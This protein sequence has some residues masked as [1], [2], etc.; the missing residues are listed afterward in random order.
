MAAIIKGLIRLKSNLEKSYDNYKKSP[1]DRLA[2][3]SYLQTRLESL[4]S[5]WKSISESHS[6]LTRGITDAILDHEYFTKDVFAD[7]E[8]IYINYKSDI[9]E[10][11]Y[12]CVPKSS[13]SSNVQ[14]I[15]KNESNVS[16]PKIN[17]PVFTGQ[18]SEWPSFRDLYTSLIHNN[19]SLDN[20]QKMHYLK[21]HLSGEAGQLLRHVPITGDS[22]QESWSI[23]NG[24]YNN[25]KYLA[26][27]LLRRFM[28]Q[29]SIGTESCSAIK[30][31]LDTTND[32]LNGLKNLGIR[33]DSWDVIIIYIICMKI[34]SE[35]RKQWE[36]KISVFD[37]LPTLPQMREFLEARFRSLEFLSPKAKPKTS[38]STQKPKVLH[39]ISAGSNATTDPCLFCKNSNHKL[40]Q[41]KDFC[42]LD[43][44][45][46]HSFVQT[47]GFCFNCLG[48]NHSANACRTSTK[49]RI[50]KHNH[51]SLLH[52]KPTSES[53]SSDSFN[54]EVTLEE[55]YILPKLQTATENAVSASNVA[56]HFSKAVAPSRILL[57][58]AIVKAQKR[59]GDIHQ[60][61][62]L[63]DQGSQASFVT[64]TVVQL[65]NLKKIPSKSIISGLGGDKGTLASRHMV[66]ITVNSQ[67]DPT[68]KMEVQAHVL[69]SITG[70][71]PS[72]KVETVEW[73]EL[74]GF[75][76]ADPDFKTPNKIDILLGADAYGEVLREGLIKGPNGRLIAQHTALGWVLSGP[77][78][79][80]HADQSSSTQS[81][82]NMI[83]STQA[84]VDENELLKKFW[85]I[86]SDIFEEKILTHEEQ[87]CEEFY[88]QTTRRD[89]S[90]RYIVELPFNEDNPQCKYGN[91]REIALKRFHHLEH[92]FKKDPE[93][94]KR[95]TEV[96]HEYLDLGHMERVT[97]TDKNGPCVYLPHHAVIRDSKTTSKIR[98]VFDASC[99]GTNGVSLNDTLMVGPTLQQDLRHIIMRWR[100]HPIC[101]SADI[102]KMYRQVLVAQKDADFQR[103]FW[104]DD[105][106][107]EIEEYRLVRVTFG[108]ASAPYLAV[109]TLQQ[110]AIDEAE[111]SASGTSEKIKTDYYVDDLL[112]GC[113][114]VVEGIR[115]YEEMTRILRKGGF[116]L[117]KWVTNNKELAK[118]VMDRE[119]NQDRK[120]DIKMDEVVKIL[121]LSW[122]KESDS[123]HYT[124][125]L[126]ILQNPVTK[127]KVISD[128]SRLFDP[129][130]WVA[131]CVIVAK[132]MIQKLW[133]SGIDWDE[134]LPDNLLEE[135]LTYR[136][137]ITDIIDFSIPRWIQAKEDDTYREI[138]GFCD[139]SNAAYAGVVYLRTI[140][141]NGAVHV[142]LVTAKTKV[143]PTMQV[144][145]PRL[146]L[147]G[148]VLVAKLST[149]VAKVLNIDKANIHGWTDST[150]VL[151]WLSSHPCRW[152]TFIANRT[153]EILSRLDSSQWSHV[154]SLQN[155]ADVASRGCT[156]SELVQND[157]WLQ[158]P[159]WLQNPTLEYKRPKIIST[160][161]EE[162]HIKAH[163]AV[164]NDPIWTRFSS[165]Q[166]LTH[167]VAFCLR[168]LKIKDVRAKRHK[169]QPFLE[170][171][172]LINALDICIMQC[173]A[174]ELQQDDSKLKSLSPYKDDKGI[175]RAQ[176]RIQNCNLSEDTKHPIIL[177]HKSHLTNL[178]IDDAHKQTLHGGP[179]LMLNYL[180]TRYW[181]ISAKGLVRRHVHKCVTC[182]RHAAATKN[183]LM[184]QLPPARVT[185]S[186]PFL[187]SG[188]DFAG[189]INI[190]VSKG[191]G[192]KSYKGYISLFICMATKA[193][194][195]EVISDLT[196]Q[197]F[198]AGFKRFVA[199]RGHV[200]HIWSDN[201]TNFVG[202]AKELRHL[203]AAEDSSVATEIRAWLGTK[204]VTWHFIPP[205]APNF[206][207]LWEAGVKSA[208]FHLKRVVNNSTLTFEEMTTVLSQ[209]EACLNSRPLSMLPNDH[210]DPSPLTPGHFLVG[211]PLIVVPERN[212]EQSNIGTLKRWQMTQRMLQDFWRR[213]SDEYLVHCL[214]RHKWT[215]LNP[216]PKIGDVVLIKE[217]NLPPARWLL[218]R[219][220]TKHPGLDK[221]TRVVT[222]KCNGVLLKRPTS[223]LCML[224]VTD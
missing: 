4:E 26:N 166:R 39:A 164:T 150:V 37:E 115:I 76:L 167:V 203:V 149:E 147:M 30:E 219:V 175:L 214:Q 29:P 209:I 8:E 16:L 123:F 69:S 205:H 50:C 171:S 41:C 57:A 169:F 73:P 13:S 3:E 111:A 139:A 222:L 106:K 133:L 162:R 182:V 33:V 58:T 61:R 198:I 140:D 121:G 223:K 95:Y 40:W 34:D 114:T 20:V 206:G 118:V 43:Y 14:S 89:S 144:S 120:V 141:A 176:G 105:P 23:L 193:I 84:H 19:S 36:A 128:I 160:D 74:A 92:R 180:R 174:T 221:I 161:L 51:H 145:I 93:I 151:A 213:W 79:F 53:R 15:C 77:T 2:K 168:F 183:Q 202:A 63:L 122:D 67:H 62:A 207:G 159:A 83:M 187:K 104:R 201:G 152:K 218:G 38:Y 156:P 49:C 124:A 66:V 212:Y 131:P 110:V 186:R 75:S 170:S 5:Q 78:H 68:F 59:N 97:S 47:N 224:P 154:Q 27:G 220:V 178:I 81:F 46:R 153:S 173:Q 60:L 96:M 165:L 48:R 7:M 11:L 99:K 98:V 179:M 197:S 107:S 91:S 65:L 85:Q 125:Q 129:L 71:L 191:R 52:P 146:E 199:R 24:R 126:P 172:E 194:H 211:E 108:T 142:N 119:G 103:L 208:K 55:K 181:I 87:Q 32:T 184:G 135:W 10:A 138:H 25:K 215:K 6:D 204:G 136:C 17:I 155:P 148:A 35:S 188:V 86:E 72:R 88:M 113:E 70:L 217:D 132:T 9:K 196:S 177:P 94:R 158:G 112:T 117:Q 210:E 101:L 12:E 82:H 109:K 31:M 195:L 45:A 54:R 42:K 137:K 1:R 185:P 192:N 157:L 100:I 22:Y 56:T 200:D 28:N 134:E 216:E 189:P 190:R 90:G 163:V 18:Y 127:R 64:E 143:A 130:G 102:I 44:D 80:N 116:E 21:G